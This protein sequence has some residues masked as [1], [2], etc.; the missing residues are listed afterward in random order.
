MRITDYLIF[1]RRKRLT[2][3]PLCCHA[4]LIRAAS[5]P[6]TQRFGI[7]QSSDIQKMWRFPQLLTFWSP[8]LISAEQVTKFI[9][10]IN[11]TILCLHISLECKLPYIWLYYLK[12]RALPVQYFLGSQTQVNS[13]HFVILQ[14]NHTFHWKNSLS[15]NFCFINSKNIGTLGQ[16][17]HNQ[18]GHLLKMALVIVWKMKY[19]IWCL[20]FNECFSDSDRWPVGKSGSQKF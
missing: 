6:P 16:L 17:L 4:W 18:T 9:T 19:Q 1:C 15:E 2:V 11:L 5:G 7:S 13:S 14:T 10:T 8:L 12:P 3:C 20:Q